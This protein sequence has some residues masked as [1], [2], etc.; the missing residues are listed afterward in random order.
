MNSVLLDRYAQGRSFQSGG[1]LPWSAFSILRPGH[2]MRLI[3]LTVRNLA[4]RPARTA[5]TVCGLAAA[6]GTVVAL[7]SVVR[8]YEQSVRGFYAAQESI[9]WYFGRRASIVQAARCRWS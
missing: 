8:S 1:C 9:W 6:I 2:D 4:R 3:T 7:V 5:L